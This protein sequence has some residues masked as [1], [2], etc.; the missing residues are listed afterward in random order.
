MSL[1]PAARRTERHPNGRQR[2]H[3]QHQSFEGTDGPCLGAGKGGLLRPFLPPTVA[4]TTST[5]SALPIGCEQFRPAQIAVDVGMS[6][7]VGIQSHPFPIGEELIVL[8]RQLLQMRQI[9]TLLQFVFVDFVWIFWLLLL[10]I[11]II[12]VFV[13]GSGG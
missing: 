6:V 9:Q 1:T 2:Q 11:M 7:V 13:V 4:T 8:R 3:Q 5:I 10:M 12:I